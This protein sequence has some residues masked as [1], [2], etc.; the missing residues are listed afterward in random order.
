MGFRQGAYATVWEVQDKGNVSSVR[1][2]ISKKD[3]NT[4]E[5]VN[6]FSGFCTFIGRAHSK[7]TNLKAKDRIKILECDVSTFYSKEKQKEYVNY[8]IFDF[9]E[10]SNITSS[11]QNS[12]PDQP[13]E[14]AAMDDDD[15]PFA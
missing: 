5:Y 15:F 12:S 8:K 10:N 9:E 1:I 3:K 2:S 14:F 7:A 4:G 13:Q 11:N 6:D